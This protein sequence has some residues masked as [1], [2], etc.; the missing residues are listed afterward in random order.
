MAHWMQKIMNNWSKVEIKNVNFSETEELQVG[1]QLDVTVDIF[2]GEMQPGDI[3][4]DV[5]Y[6]E[7]DNEEKI[8]NREM[9]RL[10]LQKDI[11]NGNHLFHGVVSCRESGKFVFGTRVIPYHSLLPNPYFP[12]L[13]FWG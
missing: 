11:G 5:Y 1:A 13:V 12:G 3:T 6:G 7:M 10:E 8:F 2:L 9:V 4:L